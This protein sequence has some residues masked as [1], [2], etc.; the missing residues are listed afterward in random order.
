MEP[1]ALIFVAIIAFL[2]FVAVLMYFGMIPWAKVT[3]RDKEYL[4]LIVAGSGAVLF[5]RG[6][7]NIADIVPVVQNPFVSLF[8]GLTI[9]TVTGFLWREF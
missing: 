1:L 7:W 9:L 4:L 3:R 5:W 6:I 8:L 2:T